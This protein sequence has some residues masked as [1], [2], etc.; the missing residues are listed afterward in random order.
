MAR[1]Y[2][3]VE[4]RP[5]AG[6]F[7]IPRL[8]HVGMLQWTFGGMILAGESRRA[9]RKTC[10]SAI[11]SIPRLTWTGLGTNPGLRSEK[12]ASDPPVLWPGRIPYLFL[13]F[14][15]SLK[16]RI[17]LHTWWNLV[18]IVTS[19][20]TWNYTHFLRFFEADYKLSMS[21]IFGS[22]FDIGLE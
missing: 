11:L 8:I 14:C 1:D 12:V 10:P 19:N 5:L 3:S 22:S 15:L 6:S 17:P 7:S 2:I 9:R 13:H 16:K 4:L 20:V 21:A 18:N